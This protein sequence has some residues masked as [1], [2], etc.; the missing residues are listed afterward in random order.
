[1]ICPES[2][3]ETHRTIS[4]AAK[5][6]S[7]QNAIQFMRKFKKKFTPYPTT[8]A[9]R[10][11]AKVGAGGT[12]MCTSSKAQSSDGTTSSAC[13]SVWPNPSLKK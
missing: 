1:M 11:A 13:S 2:R 5:V 7:V 8:K 9:S 6:S 3:S 10:N 4:C 12:S